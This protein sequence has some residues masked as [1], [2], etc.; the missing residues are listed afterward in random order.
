MSGMKSTKRSISA[1]VVIKAALL[2]AGLVA[3]TGCV[4]VRTQHGYALERGETEL[5]ARPNIDT[6]ESV[7]A[8]YGEPSLKGVL[9]DNSW[10]YVA[11]ADQARAFFRPE[12]TY[13]TVVAFHFNEEGFVEEVEQL[14]LKDS[15]NVKISS[16]E[17]PTRG[18][19]L[20]FW[21][22]LLGNVGQLPA[23]GIGGQGQNP[24]Q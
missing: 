9:D 11:N 20:S 21:E 19:E 10:Y 24:N 1:A 15:V 22:Q 4:S 17:T 7:I 14:S 23:G 2:G 6:R 12:L 16:R 13:Q 3:A 8:R 5:T 18:K